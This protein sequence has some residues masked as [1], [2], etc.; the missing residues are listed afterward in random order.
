MSKKEINKTTLLVTKLKLLEDY[1]NVL[2]FDTMFK[3][4]LRFQHPCQVDIDLKPIFST[5]INYKWFIQFDQEFNVITTTKRDYE[6]LRNEIKKNLHDK[7]KKFLKC[8]DEQNRFE[9]WTELQKCML[10]NKFV[11][12]IIGKNM[13]EL[14]CLY[15]DDVLKQISQKY[16]QI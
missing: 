9:K 12:T 6:K 13:G 16:D 1:W 8:L 4:K 7:I 11:F 15:G 5:S 3:L 14:K 10:K 2:N